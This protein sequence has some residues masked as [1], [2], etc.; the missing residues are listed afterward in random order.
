MAGAFFAAGLR[1][2]GLAAAF[3]AAPPVSLPPEAP[4][5]SIERFRAAI[6]SMTLEPRAGASSS[7]VWMV[8]PLRL[9][10]ISSSTDSI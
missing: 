1:A 4:G 8:L 10:S 5:F 9:R 7:S 2:A 6:R 3:L